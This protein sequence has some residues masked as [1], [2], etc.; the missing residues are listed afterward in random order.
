M[1]IIPVKP[2][3]KTGMPLVW[4]YFGKHIVTRYL[5][6]GGLGA[7]TDLLVLYVLVDLLGVWYLAGSSVAFVIAWFVSF[8]MQKFWTF[9]NHERQSAIV[10]RQALI[11]F[12]I[13]IVNLAL[14]TASMYVLVNY[15][16][17][18]YITAQIMTSIFIAVES[19]FAYK[20]LVFNNRPLSS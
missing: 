10:G 18:W 6:S 11:F 13:A 15:F 3:E 16:D 5:F 7:A 1:E 14:N 19:F 17:V 9:Q 8:G 4:H 20:F 2:L 12:G